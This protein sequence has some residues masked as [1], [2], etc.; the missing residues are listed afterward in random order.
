MKYLMEDSEMEYKY[1]P[2]FC[3]CLIIS[4]YFRSI[5]YVP[6]ILKHIEKEYSFMVKKKQGHIC[7]WLVTFFFFASEELF[8]GI[9][10]TSYEIKLI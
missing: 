7:E 8:I 4:L 5:F 10:N 2:D 3:C 6:Q 1:S 9:F